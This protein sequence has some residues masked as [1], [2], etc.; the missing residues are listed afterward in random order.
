MLD[1]EVDVVDMLLIAPFQPGE[2]L[3]DFDEMLIT[4]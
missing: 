4:L 2:T 3:A 1:V